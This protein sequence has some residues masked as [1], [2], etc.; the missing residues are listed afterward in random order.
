MF[1]SFRIIGVAV[2]VLKTIYE[3][4]QYRY[5]KFTRYQFIIT[6]ATALNFYYIIHC[7]D[8]ELGVPKLSQMMCWILSILAFVSPLLSPI[9]L[10]QRITSIEN[11]LVIP[12]LLMSLSYE[13]LF[14]FAFIVNLKYWIETELR[15][16]H[17]THESF[18]SLTFDL[19]KTPF[20]MRFVNLGDV[21]RVTKFVSL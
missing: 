14:F 8:N 16:H 5:S 17:E 10:R 6:L 12:F 19:E 1:L 15:L 4:V 3:L 7:L 11:A 2:W 18:D 13:P 21:R 9:S 20:Q